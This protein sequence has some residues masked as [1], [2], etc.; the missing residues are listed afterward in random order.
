MWP[1]SDLRIFDVFQLSRCV[2]TQWPLSCIKLYDGEMR[3]QFL[4]ETGKNA[5]AGM[6]K[7]IFNTRH[8]EHKTMYDLMDAYVMELAGLKE[9]NWN[10]HFFH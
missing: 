9:V 4:I 3:G 1:D 6:G 5:P 8:D 2:L 7:Y 10:V